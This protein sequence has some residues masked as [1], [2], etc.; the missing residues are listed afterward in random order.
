MKGE[1]STSDGDSK[2]ETKDSSSRE[3]HAQEVEVK[4]HAWALVSLLSNTSDIDKVLEYDEASWCEYTLRHIYAVYQ[5]HKAW[6]K[7]NTWTELW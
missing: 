2:K 3:T 6:Q 1:Y 5:I 4:T 7:S